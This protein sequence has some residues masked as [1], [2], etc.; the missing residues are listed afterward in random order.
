[1]FA[2]VSGRTLRDLWHRLP[3]QDIRA[4][5]LEELD[6]QVHVN[7]TRHW[8]GHWREIGA[9]AFAALLVGVS[10]FG[11]IELASVLWLVALAATAWAVWRWFVSSLDHFVVTDIRMMRINGVFDKKRATMPIRR[12][13]D[14]TMEQPLLGRW[15]GYGHFVFESAAQVQGLREFRYIAHPEA[16]DRTIMLLVHRRRAGADPDDRDGGGDHGDPDD[17]ADP[18]RSADDGYVWHL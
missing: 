8:A 17:A 14:I 4:H 10:P 7:E 18:E 6:E 13:L 15:F 12:V 2:W 9:L 11:P 1:M 16:V 5:L 3:R